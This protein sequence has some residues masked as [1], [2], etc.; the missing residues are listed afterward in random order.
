LTK[1]TGKNND[2]QNIT[3]KTKDQTTRAH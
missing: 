2:L 3:K 1:E